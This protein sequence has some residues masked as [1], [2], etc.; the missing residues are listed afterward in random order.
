[1]FASDVPLLR[2]RSAVILTA[3]TPEVVINIILSVVSGNRTDS[4]KRAGPYVSREGFCRGERPFLFCHRPENGA[5]TE[6]AIRHGGGT[7]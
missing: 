4:A 1:M 3:E 7:V 2:H 6:K 5:L